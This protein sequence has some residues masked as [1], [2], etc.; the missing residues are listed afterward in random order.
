[1]GRNNQILCLRNIDVETLGNYEKFLLDDGYRITD[2][3]ARDLVKMSVHI[4][5]YD[6]IFVL[7]GPMSA[8]DD[9]DYLNYEKQ[10]IARAIER[11]IPLM[12]I[13]LGSQLIA[14]ACGGKVFQGIRKEIGWGD[15]YFTKIGL[16]RV[17][18]GNFSNPLQVFHWHGDTFLPPDEA[19][20]LARNDFYIQ[21]FKYQSAIG[22]QF[23][24][25]VNQRMIM[26]WSKKYQKE[27]ESERISSDNFFRNTEEDFAR[28]SNTSKV[29]YKYFKSFFN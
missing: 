9:Y 2:I 20:I 26:D 17:F 24:I 11:R 18:G 23:H 13:C 6:A 12:G 27:L 10:L 4:D 7:G 21:A 19:E 25:E 16:E 14:A 1:M 22:I 8:N 5:E 15:V 28:L 3:M 29:L